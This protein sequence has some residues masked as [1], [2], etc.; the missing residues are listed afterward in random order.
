MAVSAG[1]TCDLFLSSYALFERFP[2]TMRSL[3]GA[4]MHKWHDLTDEPDLACLIPLLHGYGRFDTKTIHRL[5]IELMTKKPSSSSSPPGSPAESHSGGSS[6]TSEFKNDEEVED[7]DVVS[8][9]PIEE[10]EKLW[11]LRHEYA[12][13]TFPCPPPGYQQ[14]NFEFRPVSKKYYPS[15]FTS[16]SQGSFG[17]IRVRAAGSESGW[18]PVFVKKGKYINDELIAFP[19]VQEHFPPECLQQLVTVDHDAQMLFYRLFDGKTLNQ[20]RLDYYLEGKSFLTDKHEHRNGRNFLDTVNWFLDLELRRAELVLHAYT[21]TIDVN[22]EPT[23]CPKQGIHRFYH[24]RLQS[25]SRLL[26][27]YS[28]RC[29]DVL[30]LPSLDSNQDFTTSDFLNTPLIINGVT[31][32]PLRYHFDRAT[33][34]LDP[35]RQGG[36]SDLPV[37][38]GLGDGHGG[39]LM[40]TEDLKGCAARV[41]YID[42]EVSGSHCPFLDMAKSIY[43]DA[44]FNVLYAD[45]L[46]DD[47]TKS[48]PKNNKSGASVS[49]NILPDVIDI[50]YNL[51]LDTIGKTVAITKFEYVL[52]PMFDLVSQYDTQKANLSVDVLS[53]ALFTCALLTR[54]FRERADIFFLNLAIGV[55]LA[56]ELNEV[57]SETFGWVGLSAGRNPGISVDS[58]EGM[59]LQLLP[60]PEENKYLS[61]QLPEDLNMDFFAFLFS[62]NLRPDDVFL[63][64]ADETYQLQQRFSRTGQESQGTI[65]RRISAARRAGMVVLKPPPPPPPPPP[66]QQRLLIQFDMVS[67]IY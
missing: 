62:S 4:L 7:Y 23:S 32:P 58:T 11:S 53:S 21:K 16:N 39:N 48:S 55:R 66:R 13:S 64:R 18:S 47:A 2:D 1:V 29:L 3:K 46:C 43:N 45:L 19:T 52:L 51:Q 41:M 5:Q 34:I 44:F 25:D 6:A 14:G 35:N 54:C 42:Y 61:S 65:I 49:W 28:E 31:Y 33:N 67:L 9:L 30:R 56:T 12:V 57:L 22:P 50:K 8:F 10:K 37:A 20:I 40:V 59:Q 24:A 60:L 63:K 15:S 17:E 27:F 38:F 36:L 26:E